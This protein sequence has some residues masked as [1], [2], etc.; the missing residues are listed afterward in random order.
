MKITYLCKIEKQPNK[1]FLV[2]F[3]DFEEAF[4]EGDTYE[5]A[6]FNAE[7]VLSL[8]LEG[9]MEENMPIPEP[10][11]KANKSDEVLVLPSTRVQSALLVRL[12]KGN[13]TLSDLARSLQTSW[14]AAYRLENPKHWSNLK[15]LSKAA[16]AMGQKLVLSFEKQY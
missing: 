14:P 1:T 8:T 4:T 11:L 16:T 12:N 3:P 6:I 9:R 15:Q 10:T 5:E 2:S 13:K 7:E